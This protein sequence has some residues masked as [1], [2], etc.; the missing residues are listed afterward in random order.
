MAIDVLPAKP[1]GRSTL[2]LSQHPRLDMAGDVARKLI[3]AEPFLEHGLAL[4]LTLVEAVSLGPAL[5]KD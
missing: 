5:E 1:S 2:V 3:A 4:A